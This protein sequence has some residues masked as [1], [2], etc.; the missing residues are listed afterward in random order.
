MRDFTKAKIHNLSVGTPKTLKYG[1]GKEMQTAIEKQS[2]ERVFLG[3]EGFHGDQVADLKH[4]GGPDRAVCI[5]SAEHYP[6]WEQ[7][8]EKPLPPSTFGENL[9]VSGMLEQDVY[10]GDIF[11]IGDAVIQVTQ[12]RV[13]CQTID[14]RL[15]M[16]PLMKRMVKTGFTGFLCRV[17]EEGEIQA[18][19]SIELIESHPEEISVLYTNEI[20]F[21]HTKDIEGMTKILK[22]EALADEW[23]NHFEK[24]LKKLADSQ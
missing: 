22:V 24:R 2:V 19:S 20:N 21:H 13:P 18:D 4:H 3:K 14:R 12:G 16:T 17:I 8:F 1:K 5:Y 7:E 15:D 9:T 23:R 11:R 6:L 10:I